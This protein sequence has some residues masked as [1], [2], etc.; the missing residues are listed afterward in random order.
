MSRARSPRRKPSEPDRSVLNASLE[1]LR[2]QGV[3][4]VPLQSIRRRPGNPRDNAESVPAMVETM[5]GLGWTDPITVDPEGVIEAGDTRWLAAAH[6]GLAEVP[7]IVTL[8]DERQARRHVVAHNR[9]GELAA[10][11]GPKLAAI[12]EGFDPGEVR[13]TGFDPEEI[14][15]MARGPDVDIGDRDP[16]PQNDDDDDA[17]PEPRHDVPAITKPGDLW[18]LGK[19][20]VVCGDNG[21]EATIA[22]VLQGEIVDL[23]CE[24]PPFAIYG[25]STG[26]SSAVSDDRMVVPFFEAAARLAHRVSRWFGHVYVFC[27]WRSYPALR[28]GARRAELEPK[29]LLVW[30][31]G[32]GGLGSNYANTHELIAFFAKMPGKTTMKGDAAT[33]QRSVLRPNILRYQRA[34]G[35]ERPHNAAKPVPLVSELIVNSSDEGGIVADFYGGGGSTLIACE[36]TGRA[37]RLVDVSP[38]WVDVIVARWERLTGRKAERVPAEDA[39]AGAAMPANTQAPTKRRKTSRSGGRKAAGT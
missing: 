18:I 2:A 6:L 33:G 11:N 21:E 19:H 27:D 38:A 5:L 12:L 10:W 26:V 25:S 7:V 32:N 29:N 34:R 9:I 3:R 22:R 16:S 39:S 37:A 17:E 13:A 23:V 8:H 24:D 1:H 31:K 4:F 36:K 35:A 30:D 14:A 28:E 15:A 20:R